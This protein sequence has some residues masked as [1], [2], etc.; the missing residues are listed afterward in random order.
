MRT[1][2]NIFSNVYT[3]LFRKRTI[4]LIALITVVFVFTSS[5]F[6]VL[7]ITSLDNKLESIYYISN[8]ILAIISSLGIVFTLIYAFRQYESEKKHAKISKA[9]ELA[10]LYAEKLLTPISII[11]GTFSEL[12]ILDPELKSICNKLDLN[13]MIEFDYEELNDILTE[14][15]IVTMNAVANL[16]IHSERF[17][18][19][20]DSE[21]FENKKK[22]RTL[23]SVIYNTLNKMEHFCI[24]FNSGIAENATV[25]QSLHQTFFMVIKYTYTYIAKLNTDETDKYYINII[26]TYKNWRKTY[27]IQVQKI[28]DIKNKE[29]KQKSHQGT[30]K[31]PCI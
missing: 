25:Y 21:D 28:N 5:I 26:E 23:S 9:A 14:V 11:V 6:K 2:I 19:Y 24:Y 16:T 20:E 15:E 13:K 18:D 17:E 29:R 3:F 10:N 31:P 4:Y 8:I 12:E 30:V 27:N 7:N 1:I 22:E